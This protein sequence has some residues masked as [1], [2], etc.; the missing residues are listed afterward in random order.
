VKIDLPRLLV[1]HRADQAA[2][3]ESAWV[4]RQAMQAFVQTMR[5]PGRYAAAG[6]FARAGTG[7]LSSLSGGNVQFMPPPFANWT[8]S[9]DFPPFA[10]RSFREQWRDRQSGR[11]KIDD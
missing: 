8:R 9:R 2:K 11:K 10:K 6:K 3:G 4:D 7:L 1:D 5:S